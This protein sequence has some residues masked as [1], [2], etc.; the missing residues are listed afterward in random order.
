MDDNIGYREGWALSELLSF[1]HAHIQSQ[2][3]H[4]EFPEREC[5]KR[6][7]QPWDEVVAAHLR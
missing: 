4:L 2:K 3:L 6:L 5:E 1:Q 7:D